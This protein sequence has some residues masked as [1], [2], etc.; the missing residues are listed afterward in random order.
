M[1]PEHR[2]QV[3]DVT[4]Y[5]NPVARQVIDLRSNV[6]T[7]NGKRIRVTHGLQLWPNLTHEPQYCVH[8]WPVSIST[9]EQEI[10]SICPIAFRDRGFFTQNGYLMDPRERCQLSQQAALIFADDDGRVRLV[11]QLQFGLSHRRCGFGHHWIAK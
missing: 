6:G 11:Y 10:A 1:F 5:D 4:T 7:S 3:P 2:R 8:I 9:D